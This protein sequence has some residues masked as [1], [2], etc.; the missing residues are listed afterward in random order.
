MGEYLTSEEVKELITRVRSGDNEAWESLYHNFE[1][2]VHDRAWKYLRKFNLPEERKKDMEEELYQAGWQG[3]LSS[4]H[5][6]DQEKGEFLTYATHYIDGEMWKE[7]DF[8]LNPL[9]FTERVKS[10]SGYAVL[11]MP[12]ALESGISVE[13]APD[14]GKYS[15]ERR[16]LQIMEILHLLTDEEHSLSKEE[17]GNLLYLYRIAKYHNSTS[18]EAQNTLTSTIENMLMEVNPSEYTVENN[19]KYKIKY[20]GY[21][22]N[23]LK[24]KRNKKKGKKAAEITGFSYVHTFDRV[25]LDSL[26]QLVCFSDMLSN[27]EKQRLVDKLVSTAS[28]YYRTPFQSDEEPGDSPRELRFNPKAIHGRFSGRIIKDNRQF[29]EKINLIQQAV[30]GLCQIRFRF[31]RYTAEHEMVPK[32]EYLHVLSPYHLV[33]YHDNYY[34]IGLTNKDKRI[35]HYRVDLMSD[36]EILTDADGKV[37]PINLCAFEGLPIC[38]ACW[39]PEKYMAEHLYMAYDEPKEI[40]I[41]I[42]NLDYTILHDWFGNHYEKTKQPCEEGYD[43]VK[44]RTSPSMIVHWAVQYADAVEVMDEEIRERIRDEIKKLKEKY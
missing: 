44:V 10:D 16:V 18:L 43:I 14:L 2:Y 32:S 17:L 4:V 40:Q 26:I 23:R 29:A 8:A 33:V 41:K 31:N 35:W 12:R 5:A 42:K 19:G 37:I 21:K 9:G 22:E 25:E 7:M 13:E 39:D 36:V 28:V 30:N 11:Q 34:C 20:E 27:E 6:Y 24:A 15:A 3:F 1:R 38:N